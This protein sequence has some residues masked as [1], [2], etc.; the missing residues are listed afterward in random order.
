[1]PRL[2]LPVLIIIVGLLSVYAWYTSPFASIR[3]RI[4]PSSGDASTLWLPRDLE[5]RVLGQF[6]KLVSNGEIK[7]QP[8]EPEVLDQGGF[9][10]S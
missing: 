6:D 8:S 7:F 1:M 5:S 3:Y 9:Q 2:S 4:T 10:V